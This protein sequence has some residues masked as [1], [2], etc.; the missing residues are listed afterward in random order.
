[1]PACKCEKHQLRI[2][3][4]NNNQDKAAHNILTCDFSNLNWVRL[5]HASTFSSLQFLQRR[6][7]IFCLD[8]SLY[9]MMKHHDNLKLITSNALCVCARFITYTGD[10]LIVIKDK[11]CAN[12]TRFIPST[13]GL[14]VAFLL[15]KIRWAFFSLIAL[16]CE[17]QTRTERNQPCFLLENT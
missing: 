17:W 9:S 16:K 10:F 3:W 13:A 11:I 8:D 12:Y 15:S 5:R 7:E 6:K 1:M 14:L 4:W 2:W